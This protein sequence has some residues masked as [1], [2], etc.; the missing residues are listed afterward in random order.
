MCSRFGATAC[1]SLACPFHQ[2]WYKGGG[3]EGHVPHIDCPPSTSPFIRAGMGGAE[4]ACAPDP[5]PQADYSWP[6]PFHQSCGK[7]EHERKVPQIHCPP[8]TAPFIRAGMQRGVCSRFKATDCLSLTLPLSS[9]LAGGGIR[10]SCPRLSS[11]D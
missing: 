3:H 1:L 6:C 11:T 4:G 5:V 2:R 7:G 9:E 10:G 8:G